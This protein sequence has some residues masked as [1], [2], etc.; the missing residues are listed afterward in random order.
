MMEVSDPEDEPPTN[1]LEI[2]KTI[3]VAPI[4]KDG[5]QEGDG[6]AGEEGV[7]GQ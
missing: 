2:K 4:F 3:I 7:Q 6:T 5:L 1:L